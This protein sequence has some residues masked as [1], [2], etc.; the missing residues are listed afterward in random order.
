[1]NG[2]TGR[3]R[4]SAILAADAAGYSRLME[5]DEGAT[6]G[7]LESARAMFRNEIEAHQGRVVN[8]AGDSILA[9]F[10]SAA[11]AVAAA[12]GVQA[13]LAAHPLM[14]IAGMPLRFRI[15]VHLGDV[16]TSADGD[17]HGDGVNIAA[18]LQGLADP[19]GIIASEAVRGA[20]KSRMEAT[21][22]DRGQQRVKN[23]ADPV[24]AFAVSSRS[25]ASDVLLTERPL[26]RRFAWIAA[27][28]GLIVALGAIAIWMR[29]GVGRSPTAVVT[30]SSMAAG[31][32]TLAV[33]PFDNIG[34]DPEQA[35]LAEGIT[36]DLITDLAKVKRLFVIARH[37]SFAYGNQSRDAREIGKALG[38]QYI[39]DGSVRRHDASVRVNA[40]LIDT[41]TGGQLWADHYEENFNNIF[42]L[43][44]TVT[45]SVVK[46][47]SVELT[48]EDRAR[49][50]SSDTT[51]VNAY[52]VFLRGWQHYL[53]QTPDDFRAAIA[54]FEKAAALDPNYTRAYAALAATHWESYTRF[55]GQ[56]VE[57]DI[58]NDDVVYQ[59]EQAL[60]KAMRSPTPLAHQV[61]SAMSLYQQQYDDAIAEAK[62]AVATDPSDADGYIALARSLSFAG[63]PSE[64]LESV[65]YA[66]K[67][68]PHYP[69]NYLYELGLAHFAA[70]QIADATA[71]LERAIAMNPD[72]YWSQRLLVST[73][74]LLGRSD[75]AGRLI[76]AM[77]AKDRRGGQA[78]TDPLTIRAMTYWYPFARVDDAKRFR[79][80]LAK[81][82]IP[83]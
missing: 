63:R 64:A 54:D 66:M 31:R 15:G 46:A 50:T 77:K 37:S 12:L 47:L 23:I 38:V 70:N 68:N 80:G 22:V 79:E 11:A 27:A 16:I 1:M 41:S 35:Y 49:V 51:N 36:D 59:A 83:A 28:C 21:F 19:G 71:S 17:V 78:F 75:E 43:Q 14:V 40:Q 48:Q 4:L 73:Y 39:L 67:I 9:L 57:H 32:T 52:D 3:Q 25:S 62:Q 55:W 8:T 33:L 65:M 45:K 7:A 24:R 82:G 26:R 2:R 61:A 10:D 13:K 74:G 29:G 44:D 18:R 6:V 81:A 5:T 34:G 42:A 69:S 60:D 20:V 76:Q 30:P 53:R 56:E 72:D 58:R